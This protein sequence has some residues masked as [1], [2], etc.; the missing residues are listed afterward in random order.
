MKNSPTIYR[1]L[2][3]RAKEEHLPTPLS[4]EVTTH[5]K[6]K[7]EQG[8]TLCHCTHIC[9]STKQEKVSTRGMRQNGNMRRSPGRPRYIFYNKHS[10][11]FRPRKQT[12]KQQTHILDI[13]HECSMHTKPLR[14]N[15]TVFS[16]WSLPNCRLRGGFRRRKT[17]QYC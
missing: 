2:K 7:E 4:Q 12:K 5:G 9:L 6:T 10:Q 16:A 3:T 1:R 8:D 14:P 11:G 17:Y 13:F 15:L